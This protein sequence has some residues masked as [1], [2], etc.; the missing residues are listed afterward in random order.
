MSFIKDSCLEVTTALRHARALRRRGGPES[1]VRA[2]L[3]YA[4][5]HLD[6]IIDDMR[7][8]GITTL[9]MGSPP[10]AAMEA[11]L[12]A[13]ERYLPA[14]GP[15]RR[16]SACDALAAPDSRRSNG[17]RAGSVDQARGHLGFLIEML[18]HRR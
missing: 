9:N 12:Q 13:V 5:G 2:L 16:A 7:V 10:I 8:E 6:A 11:A 18:H 14:A 4:R 1:E 17:N 15:S 3:R